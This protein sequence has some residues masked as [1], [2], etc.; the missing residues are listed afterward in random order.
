VAPASVVRPAVAVL[1]TSFLSSP[2]ETVFFLGRWLDDG[3]WADLD[4]G[5]GVTG[6]RESIRQELA[7][8][9]PASMTLYIQSFTGTTTE[10]IRFDRGGAV[11]LPVDPDY[12]PPGDNPAIQFQT[13]CM[14]V[15][16]ETWS[17]PAP[18]GWK[19]MADEAK[20]HHL[21]GVLNA[22]SARLLD[23]E[24]GG[25]DPRKVD[26]ESIELVD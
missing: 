18:R 19:Q 9:R 13:W 21:Q 10:A 2:T 16:G 15:V 25:D 8:P 11:E 1:E 3:T 23:E 14:A 22:N 4:A 24:V 26:R 5:P 7:S 6:L 17:T 12:E 20:A